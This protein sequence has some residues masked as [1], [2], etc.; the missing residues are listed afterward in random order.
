M[1]AETNGT[2]E[3][4][5]HEKAITKMNEA[6]IDDRL[7]WP[8]ERRD[9]SCIRGMFQRWTYSYMRHVLDAGAKQTLDDGTHLSKENLFAVPTSMESTHLSSLFWQFHSRESTQ[10]N[11]RRLMVTLWKLA[12]PT[13]IPAGFCQLMTVFCQVAMPL[14]VRQLLTILED[15]P[16][17][18]VVQLGLPY[19]VA[20]FLDL[21]LN[22]FFNH[23]QR[24]LAMKTGVVLRAS[25]ITVLYERVLKLTPQGRSGLTSGL[26]STLVSV[27]S[28]KLFEVAQEG[29][30]LW[31]LPLSVLMV[32]ALL[33]W[34]MGPTTLVGIAVL[35]MF[36]PVV[37]KVTSVSLAIRQKRVTKTDERIEI[38]NA[39]LQGIKVT[40]LNCYEENYKKRIM[41]TRE[42][43]VALLKR[44]LSVWACTL[45]MT[46][47]SPVLATAATFSV[48]VLVDENNIL[49]A[50]KSFS[51][52]L[53]FAALRFPI[54]YAGRLVG[55]AAQALSAIHRLTRFLD[56]DV[57]DDFAES[58]SRDAQQVMVKE[59]LNDTKGT[60]PLLMLSKAAFTV[61]VNETDITISEFDLSVKR[62]EV[63]AVCGPV[64]SGK[65]SLCLGIIDELSKASSDT[66]VEL[67]GNVAFVPQTPFIMNAT[68][69]E[70]IMFG[71]PFNANLYETVLDACQLRHDIEQLGKAGDLT[72]IG[73]RG[74]TLSGGQRQRVSLARAAYSRP[75]IVLLDD[76]LSALD[77]G[78]AKEVFRRL[79]RGEASLF[80]DAAVI[81]VTHASQ[82]L[83]RCDQILLLVDGKNSFLG[84]WNDLSKFEPSDTK[85]KEA[86]EHLQKSLQEGQK[87]YDGGDDLDADVEPSTKK[88]TPDALMTI[89]EREHGL[90]SLNTWLLWFRHAGGMQFLG[91]LI[92]AMIFDRLA[93]VASEFWLA[94]WTGGADGPVTV[95]GKEYPSQTDGRS[96]QYQYLKVYS[97]ILL[98]SVI[99]TIARSEWAVTGGTR[100][101]R[102]VFS[103]ML[104]QVLGCPLTYFETTPMGRIVNRFTYD[105]E[106]VDVSLTQ[107]M[108]V[109]LISLGW[110]F[111]GV[112]VMAVILPY[113]L[114][115]ILPVTW[116]YWLLLL[117]YRKSG[118]DLQRLDAVS[119]SPVQAMVAEALD[120]SAS[121]RVFQK[122][123]TFLLKYFRAVDDNTSA[124]LNFVSA[125]RWL[126]IRIE[127]LGSMV[128][129]VSTSLVVCLNDVFQLS[130][131]IIGLM[132][133]WSSN[134]TITLGF[135]VDA[136]G[137]AEAAITA[138]ERVD[139]MSRLKQENSMTTE[140]AKRPASSWPEKGALK[141]HNVCLRY[142][143]G[144]PLALNNLS[145][146]IPPGKRVAVCG[147]TGAGK[148]SLAVALFRLVEIESGYIELD[149][150]DLGAL[151]LSDVRG[152]A[153]GMAII[154]QDPFLAGST[155]RQCLDPFK[156]SE[157][158]EIEAALAAVRLDDT[159]S[160]DTPVHEG[161]SNFSVG[162]RQLFNLARALL[163]QP[164][165]L[166]MDE[167][168]SSIDGATDNF[169][170]KMLRTRFP[171]TTLVTV[172]HRLNTVVDY[173][174]VVVMQAGVAAEVG[175]P[176]ELLLKPDS[177]FSELVDNTGADSAKALRAMV[178]I[179]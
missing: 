114:C 60:D 28:Q 29:H 175:A 94:R 143:S 41:E 73:E 161:G 48:Y 128:V 35:L 42:Q 179:S 131:G 34:V 77:S 134:F 49:T 81:L 52:L 118:A 159:I 53:L 109:L 152:R 45:F 89:E 13:F 158:A 95:F 55:R 130:P 172:A 123:V 113:T 38:I 104:T 153:N 67:K 12:A 164:K 5:G 98:F 63:L 15:Y 68:L 167:A 31:S 105:M 107:N 56:R 39:M 44:E 139:A 37:G 125:Q 163:S 127:L 142:R 99:G 2:N 16:G 14:L 1:C 58:K 157:D 138:I 133:I 72:E 19:A 11:K 160:L 144:L 115:A 30:L 173:D 92:L 162:E 6:S 66:L 177:L 108:S 18:R 171:D 132:V 136:F 83:S 140:E 59:P 71:L 96:A 86:V 84:S 54:N 150:V 47:L 119:R 126:G 148:S 97:I 50:A 146:E 76:P 25:L 78:T 166:V 22:G 21:I 69:R 3:F 168:T 141:F 101:A 88:T 90:S 120:G 122:Q 111:A 26:V 32:T 8:E 74:V 100:A 9:L 156:Q 137:E 110:Y 169:I 91:L 170:Q 43:E 151:G 79:I 145:L 51:V 65:S 61:G 7:P 154:P 27:D 40:K 20:I 103:K 135:L 4:D 70:N 149:G 23:R 75:D 33:L 112:L 106:V 57:R 82:F 87:Q 64:G 17:E 93:Y 178:G 36:V 165:V 24:H 80:C 102:K 129:L 174:E 117:H 176:R 121:I 155:V 62:G 10:T 147:R 124:L 46:V 116:L 85:T